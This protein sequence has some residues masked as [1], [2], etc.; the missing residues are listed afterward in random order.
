MRGFAVSA[1]LVLCA[2][3]ATGCAAPRQ[4]APAR[5]PADTPACAPGPEAGSPTT[6][7]P[8]TAPATTQPTTA[9]SSPGQQPGARRSSV[10]SLLP[11]RPIYVLLGPQS[12]DVKFQFST[13]VPLLAPGGP[14]DED[15][16][17]SNLYVA[18][19]QVSLWDISNPQEANIDTT[20][21]PEAFFA[22]RT[23]PFEARRLGA[24]ALGFQIGVQHESNGRSGEDS[25][26][27][28][29]VYVQPSVYFGDPD[30]VHGE[31]SP[32]GRV[33]FGKQTDN[34][35]IEDFMGYVELF[36]AL[37]FG[38]GLHITATGRIGENADKGSVQLD[39]TYPL[40]RFR[41]DAYFQVQYFNGFAETLLGYREHQQEIRLG[42]GFVR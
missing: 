4:P 42:V 23:P 18:Y 8:D 24:S 37:R 36:G 9:P 22:T 27:V 33:Y 20:F 32:K 29:Y 25:R 17:L 39:A 30:K 12:P 13:K 5:T 2:L 41:L 3:A 21:M 10:P 31:F 16:V 15:P 19:T 11:H 35:D 34:P 7:A 14:E 6:T 28:N 40:N 26:N 1:A 38:D